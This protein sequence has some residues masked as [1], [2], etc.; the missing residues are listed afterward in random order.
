MYFEDCYIANEISELAY[1]LHIFLRT[2]KLNIY[3]MI[4][5]NFKM[6]TNACLPDDVLTQWF[7][8][9]KNLPSYYWGCRW[10]IM[11]SWV[12]CF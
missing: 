11:F 9:E 3:I 8:A 6:V 7:L 1:T 10:W 2:C 4:R 12:F 5:T